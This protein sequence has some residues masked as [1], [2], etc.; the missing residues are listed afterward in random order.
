MLSIPRFIKPLIP[1]RL[2]PL[3]R[4][5]KW[6]LA[7][8]ER[9]L[10]IARQ[11][12]RR[13]GGHVIDIGAHQGLY[14]VNLSPHASRVTAFEANPILAEALR[15][16][17]S[18][19]VKVES[20]AL[21]NTEG[22]VELRIPMLGSKPGLGLAT[23][24]D[25]NDLKLA[26]ATGIQLVKSRKTTLDRYLAAQSLADRVS[27][28]KIDVEGHEAEVID[29]AWKTIASHR[30]VVLVEA[31]YRHGAD[32]ERLLGRFVE[33]G[34]GVYSLLGANKALRLIDSTEIKKMQTDEKFQDRLS[35]NRFGE[36][37]NNFFL[38]PSE[39]Q[40]DLLA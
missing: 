6:M 4:K 31:E 17:V 35:G 29:G 26:A 9:E 2:L 24:S 37:V 7:P 14:T 22:E 40:G 8:T 19:K 16:A 5:A 15:A 36:Y 30:P 38:I 34:Y 32:V 27:F 28:I 18:S 10:R 3:L 21:S 23:I 11:M 1:K 39:K 33:M 25:R 12:V 13:E 20:L